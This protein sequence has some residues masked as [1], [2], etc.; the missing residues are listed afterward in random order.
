MTTADKSRID[1][2]MKA[3]SAEA[4]TKSARGAGDAQ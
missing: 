4:R 3:V 1:A 2:L